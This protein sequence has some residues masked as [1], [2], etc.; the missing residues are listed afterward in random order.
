MLKTFIIRL[1]A[2]LYTSYIKLRFGNKVILRGI[3]KPEGAIS[4]V[5]EKNSKLIIHGHITL[6]ANSQILVRESAQCEIGKGVFINRNCSLVCRN[7]IVIG[8]ETLIGENVK[9]YD[10]DHKIVKN[11]PQKSLYDVEPIIIGKNVWLANDVNVLKGSIVPD[12]SVV[13]AMSLV[14]RKFTERGVYLG[15]PAKLKKRFIDE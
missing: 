8:E 12:Y 9:I 3:I 6:R 13:G 11:I 15:I 10:N 14:N 7:S 5:V 1:K 4:I 2:I